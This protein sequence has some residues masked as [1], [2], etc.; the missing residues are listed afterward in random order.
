MKPP[1]KWI[2]GLE[3]GMPAVRGA[4]RVLRARLGAVEALLVEAAD[5]GRPK[6]VHRLRVAARRAAAALDAFDDCLDDRVARRVRKRLR[7]IRR[8][9]GRARDCDVHRR[10]LAD[11]RARAATARQSAL[12]WLDERLGAERK[13]MRRALAALHERYSRKTLRRRHRRL[14]ETLN[15]PSFGRGDG[16]A[17][18]DDGQTLR[19]AARR[20]MAA[21][22]AD[23]RGAAEADLGQADN[24]HTLR[25]RIKDLRY[26]LEVFRPCW[27]R[28][29]WDRWFTLFED[30]QVRLGAVNDARSVLARLEQY[31]A[32]GAPAGVGALVR[33]Y[34]ALVQRRR[35]A[36][37]QHWQAVRRA[38]LFVELRAQIERDSG[39]GAAATL[40]ADQAGTPDPLPALQAVAPVWNGEYQNGSPDGAG[41]TALARV[42]AIDVGTNSIRLIIAEAL[43]GGSYRVLDDEKEVT[44]LGRGLHDTGAMDADS[45][46]LSTLAIARMKSIAE[47]YGVRA[48][49]VVGTSAVREASN[50]HVLLELVRQRTGLQIDTISGQ[51]EA[52]LAF[53]S[54]ARA[55]DLSSVNAAV[56]D[57]GGGSTE[58]VFSTGDLIDRAYTMP[59]GAVRLTE[60][61]GG[62]SG[63]AGARY[64]D[65]RR[66]IRKTLRRAIGRAP[67]PPQVLIGTG[68]TLTTLGS[69]CLH[70]ELG[71]AAEGLFAGSVQGRQVKRAEVRHALDLLRQMP[72]RE[73][74]HVPG[75][76]PDRADIIIA[77]LA[78]VEGVME[79]LGVN[80]LLVHE[81]GIRDGLL[82][83]MVEDL[84][85]GGRREGQLDPLGS[86]RRFAHA[87][88][89]EHR[90]S[91][92]VADLCLQIFD[93]LAARYPAQAQTR[94]AARHRMLLEAGAIVHDVGYLINY[95]EHHKH[96]YHLVVHA[97]L[98]GLASREVEVIANLARYHRL[99]EPKRRH[100]NFARLTDQDRD[101]VR[102]L[103]AILRVA[104]G[105][106]RTHRQAVASVALR[107]DDQRRP[108]TPPAPVTFVVQADSEPAVDIWG[109]SRKAGLFRKVFGI[110]VRYEWAGPPAI[111]PQPGA[112]AADEAPAGADE[113]SRDAAPAPPALPEVTV[114]AGR[115]G[116]RAVGR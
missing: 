20:V 113:R 114:I 61:F 86:I 18:R 13:Q 17:A 106:D 67:L 112:P 74:S 7:R 69:L 1:G 87:C 68:G 34:R 51:Q 116:R 22:L 48:L 62:P 98:A 28:A 23:V 102:W 92:H 76:S 50:A 12:R 14:L 40:P 103:S 29:T 107:W 72:L 21:R 100:P 47:G 60:R 6:A 85:A 70:A 94:F 66:A 49:R 91:R 90:H 59:L 97:D 63:A 96:S 115:R 15:E 33:R 45:I 80:R 109:S 39:P 19:Q 108:S 54:A 8:V 105:L 53:R 111:A 101:L 95:A 35:R 93:Q 57:V 38:G 79:H 41:R 11:L 10:I 31:V 46:R 26:A 77:G 104:D 32:A 25:L 30:L 56:M 5:S 78:I 75:L 65:L 36:F 4:R 84:R 83:S 9:A 3:P 27:E 73:R 24:L 58:V 2:S 110:D 44:R 81:G 71:A 89:Y 64:D 99:A 55:F 37:L 16:R 82:L 88:G 52:R 43:E 42:G